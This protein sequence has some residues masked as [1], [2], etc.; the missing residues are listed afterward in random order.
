M[1]KLP[2]SR[3]S[4][5]LAQRGVYLK[6]ARFKLREKFWLSV[7]VVL[8]PLIVISHKAKP[9]IDVRTAEST[10][11]AVESIDIYCPSDISIV[12]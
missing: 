5:A 1:A 6:V 7:A 11:I 9:R 12:C 10:R 3:L 8:E 4:Q 2:V